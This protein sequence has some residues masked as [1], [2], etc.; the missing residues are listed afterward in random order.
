MTSFQNIYDAFL[1][2]INSDDWVDEYAYTEEE[3]FADWRAIMESAIIRFKF[4][5]IDL[6]RT[7]EGFVNEL[8]SEEIQVIA[9][10]MKLEWL[11]RTI[12]TWENVKV[13]YEEKDFSQANLLDKFT[14]LLAVTKED[15]K[16]IE[17]I[18]YRSR[19]GKSYQFSKLAGGDN[20][21]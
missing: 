10:F 8:T 11:N 12:L 17:R 4:P 20:I 16:E 7:N 21:G 19:K 18:Y 9:C 1:A 15:V 6:E 5:R 2:K 13:Q 14:K 3:V